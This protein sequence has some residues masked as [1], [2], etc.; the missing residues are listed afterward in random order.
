MP[1]G[2]AAS[3]RV[4]RGMR[5]WDAY[6]L[7]RT[8]LPGNWLLTGGVKSRIRAASLL[9]SYRN[10][11][12][13]Y[14]TH[15]RDW[16]ARCRTRRGAA[17]GSRR[18]IGDWRAKRRCRA[19]AGDSSRSHSSYPGCAAG[20]RTGSCPHGQGCGP[21]RGRIPEA[22]SAHRRH[23]V[24]RS[25]RSVLPD[26]CSCVCAHPVAYALELREWTGSPGVLGGCHHHGGL[27]LSEHQLILESAEE[28]ECATPI[29]LWP[30]VDRA[31]DGGLRPRRSSSLAQRNRCDTESS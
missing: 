5:R 3:A 20:G 4:R 16:S 17:R 25:H 2:A 12:T 7:I 21:G 19:G 30:N 28:V 13:N 22:V 9:P 10:E 23:P 14:R 11:T 29:S 1:P 26:F 15:A 6:T 31:C 27:S 8:P 18:A 24:A